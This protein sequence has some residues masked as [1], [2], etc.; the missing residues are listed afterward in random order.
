MTDQAPA[1][2]RQNS[3]KK[4]RS[5]LF[6]VYFTVF[7]DL[8][9]F[10]IILPSLPYYAEKLGAN[11]F[12]L[13]LLFTSYS[14][15]QMFGAAIL[16]R[17]SDRHG[18]RP[19]LLLSLVGSTISFALTGLAGTLVTLCLARA[20]AGLFG[21]SISTAKAYIADVT[22]REE[23][24]RYMGLLGAS[25]GMGF[26][27]GPSLGALLIALGYGFSAAAFVAAGLAAINFVLALIRL[28]EPPRRQAD[29]FQRY[30]DVNRWFA[31]LK[32]PHLGRVLAAT[33]C[34]TFA[35][36]GMET[37]FAYLGAERFDLNEMRFGLILAYVG[38]IGIIV[39]G[40]LIGRLTDRFG[41]RRIAAVG[42]WSLGA[43]LLM[44]P[45][46]P[47]LGVAFA[48]MGLLGVGQAMVSPTLSTLVSHL[49][50]ED[51]QGSTLGVGQSLAALAR[52]IGPLVAGA[53]Y[54]VGIMW[55]YLLGGGMAIIAG[56]L[57]AGVREG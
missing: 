44:L 25:I 55:P 15:A 20:L 4:S 8:L 27:L 24:A 54:D 38:V 35:F 50:D 5:A 52:A 53:L 39:Q 45:W 3:S 51:Q 12:E 42:G 6:V 11:G 32:R 29:V 57:V 56:V 46:V 36:V 41:V 21:G 14:L 23:R 47:S 30:L 31:A 43:A 17:L 10:G 16:G 34:T 18:R 22:S 9:G 49:S 40:G 26:V 48:V 7:L 1:Q 28:K 37:T 2:E 13:G 33:F 19:I